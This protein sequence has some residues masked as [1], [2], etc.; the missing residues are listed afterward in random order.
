MIAGTYRRDEHIADE[1][2]PLAKDIVDCFRKSWP[3]DQCIQ[4][5]VKDRKPTLNVDFDTN[6]LEFMNT[7]RNIMW[8]EELYKQD[9]AVGKGYSYVLSLLRKK[10]TPSSDKRWLLNLLKDKEA[11]VYTWLPP[12]VRTTAD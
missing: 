6:A 10:A 2:L 11:W 12:D 1:L 4:Y 7:L 3:V 8:D 5:L 9:H